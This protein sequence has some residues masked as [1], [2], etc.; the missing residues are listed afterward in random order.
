MAEP[1]VFNLER[2]GKSF[3]RERL[4]EATRQVPGVP[5]IWHIQS[6]PSLVISHCRVPGNRIEEYVNL[7]QCGVFAV[8]PINEDGSLGEKEFLDCDHSFLGPRNAVHLRTIKQDQFDRGVDDLWIALGAMVDQLNRL[9][10]DEAVKQLF[11]EPYAETNGADA[12]VGNATSTTTETPPP[13][14]TSDGPPH[15]AETPPD[16]T[17]AS[18]LGSSTSP[19]SMSTAAALNS[20]EVAVPSP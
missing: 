3:Y 9:S 7:A 6:L 15:E 20:E 4:T 13:N 17:L 11:T 18:S 2:L 14:D 1:K 12:D 10:E 16:A 8:T 5:F 19:D